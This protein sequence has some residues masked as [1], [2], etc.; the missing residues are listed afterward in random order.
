[1]L[2]P[3]YLILVL[4]LSPIYTV[5][6]SLIFFYW[7][8]KQKFL[9]IFGHKLE[10]TTIVAVCA[11][12]KPLRPSSCLTAVLV[13][14]NH[15]TIRVG[16]KYEFQI[17]PMI[18]NKLSQNQSIAYPTA[19][20]F[21]VVNSWRIPLST[22]KFEVHCK[23]CKDYGSNSVSEIWSMIKNSKLSQNESIAYPMAQKFWL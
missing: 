5:L 9:M 12:Q 4:K 14:P 21:L 19:R 15:Y 10:L 16:L 23:P 7:H 22:A 20:K 2:I 8:Q 11:L 1:M 13:R 18:K 6:F 17:W 3:Q